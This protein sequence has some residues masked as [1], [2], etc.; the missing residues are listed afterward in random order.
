M[1]SNLYQWLKLPDSQKRYYQGMETWTTDKGDGVGHILATAVAGRNA[2]RAIEILHE[3]A[4]HINLDAKNKDGNTALHLAYSRWNESMATELVKLGA[5]TT[6]ENNVDETPGDIARKGRTLVFVDVQMSNND[7]LDGEIERIS[8]VLTDNGLVRIAVC[9]VSMVMYDPDRALHPPSPTNERGETLVIVEHYVDPEREGMD[10]CSNRILQFLWDHCLKWMSIMVGF[11]IHLTKEIL[12]RKLKPVHDFFN[13]QILNLNTITDVCDHWA[14][15]RLRRSDAAIV[16][17][18]LI[19]DDLTSVPSHGSDVFPAQWSDTPTC[20]PFSTLDT[21]ATSKYLKE[22][23]APDT[24]AEKMLAWLD[25]EMTK[26]PKHDVADTKILEVAIILTDWSLQEKERGEW[27]IG[28]D[29]DILKGMSPWH[30]K[31]FADEKKGGNGLI[32]ASMKSTFKIEDVEDLLLALLRKHCAPQAAQLAGFSVHCDKEVLRYRMPRAHDYFSASVIDV[33]TM[34]T[35]IRRWAP[36]RLPLWKGIRG[37]HRSLPDC[38]QAMGRLQQHRT[39]LGFEDDVP[40]VA[41]A[42]TVSYAVAPSNDIWPASGFQSMQNGGGTACKTT[43][44]P[45]INTQ[46]D[47]I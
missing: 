9:N 39:A 16:Q 23:S 5:S 44:T 29:H 19:C 28:I 43:L 42:D 8:L 32:S 10:E 36:A 14:P 13:H 31:H 46:Y 40:R 21:M 38:I 18:R 26:D 35:L 4:P 22:A 33:S 34:E 3:C 24:T 1:V 37:A 30:Q 15:T 41:C 20:E 47:P 45:L 17:A 11:N 25:L 27:V 7:I 2:S 12:R 6:V